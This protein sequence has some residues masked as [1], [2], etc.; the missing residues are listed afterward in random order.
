MK[1]TAR[2]WSAPP[3]AVQRLRQLLQG[4]DTVGPLALAVA[5]GLLA[6]GGAV[7]LRAM[8]RAVQWVFFDQGTRLDLL[9]GLPVPA[10]AVTVAAP[11][12]GLV[13]VVAILRSW[14]PEARGHGVPEVQFAVR[15]RGGKIR[16]RVAA[17]KAITSAISIGS[18]GSVGREGPIVQIGSTLGSAV[19]Q[20]VGMGSQEMRILV[21]AGAAGAIGATF[22]APIAGVIFALEVILGSFAARSFGLVVVSAVTAT[23][24]AQTFLGTEPAFRLVEEFALVSTWELALYPILGIV[25]GL[26]ALLYVHAVYGVE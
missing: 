7:L 10:W 20:L 11:A 21:A 8:I 14:A 17:A 1:P 13:L 24:V 18:G 5:V 15:M 9:T 6:G 19:A 2:V 22:N 26:I 16:P 23:A 12:L 25:T 4:S 3:L